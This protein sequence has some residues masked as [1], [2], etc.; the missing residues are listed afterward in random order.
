MNC[1]KVG[2]KAE[3]AILKDTDFLKIDFERCK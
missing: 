3:A 2:A 1:T